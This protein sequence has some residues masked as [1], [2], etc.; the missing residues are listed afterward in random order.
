VARRQ[1]PFICSFC[2]KRR[3]QTRRLIA[4]PNGIYMCAECVALCNEIL[5]EGRGE[6]SEQLSEEACE[7]R[8]PQRF[9]W[10]RLLHD[11]PHRHRHVVTSSHA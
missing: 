11:W 1:G 9:T 6:A 8:A 7:T 5:A 10:R 3:E 4:G 2:G